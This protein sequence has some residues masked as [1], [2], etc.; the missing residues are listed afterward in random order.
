VGSAK[1]NT[2][3]YSAF[4]LIFIACS[5]EKGISRSSDVRDEAQKILQQFSQP[6]FHSM[7]TACWESTRRFYYMVHA[8]ENAGALRHSIHYNSS[9][10]KTMNDPFRDDLS[11]YL[12]RS[13]QTGRAILGADPALKG[14]GITADTSSAGW[15]IKNLKVIPSTT[16][17]YFLFVDYIPST[18]HSDLVLAAF[19]AVSRERLRERK[20]IN[21]VW[22]FFEGD[23]GLDLVREKYQKR[24]QAY[25]G[26]SGD[27]FYQRAKTDRIILLHKDGSQME[28]FQNTSISLLKS[29][30]N[31]RV[32]LEELVDLFRNI[33]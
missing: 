1:I 33:L 14:D 18:P 4:L 15:M 31:N 3:A 2:I 25:P 10:L 6:E 28:L 8:Y 13:S 23:L 22:Y 9:A 26:F 20:K 29:G 12:E 27:T 17:E 5:P 24:L 11:D 30:K 21:A 7:N 19:L 32:I 16:P